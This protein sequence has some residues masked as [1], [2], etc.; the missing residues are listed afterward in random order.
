MGCGGAGAPSA[1]HEDPGEAPAHSVAVGPLVAL[2]ADFGAVPLG[3]RGQC[4][5]RTPVTLE[6]H[7]L[8]RGG[9]AERSH[10]HEYR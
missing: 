10:R 4:P 7:R 5:N 1:F 2:V 9:S 6:R 3:G 8:T